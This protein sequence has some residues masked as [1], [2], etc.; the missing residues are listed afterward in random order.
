MM[1]T[2]FL[3]LTEQ[4]V[5]T[6]LSE[7]ITLIII[8]YFLKVSH[9]QNFKILHE[10]Y[11]CSYSKVPMVITLAVLMMG[12]I[13]KGTTLSIASLSLVTIL[14]MCHG[15]RTDRMADTPAAD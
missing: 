10:W 7:Y 13:S 8:A 9:L 3:A 1:N 4:V 15:N 2:I 5:I 6:G 12:E 14:L 11:Y